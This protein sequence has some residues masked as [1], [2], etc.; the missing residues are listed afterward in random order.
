MKKL[1]IVVG[2]GA[3]IDFGLP[4]VS[5]VDQILDKAASQSHPLASDTNSNLYRYL[6]E[7]LQEYFAHSPIEHLRKEAT[8]E[9]VL[10]QINSLIPFTADPYW[11][12]GANALFA[13]HRI[14]EVLGQHW[15]PL[16]MNG[17]DL[18]QL[19]VAL[20]DALVFHFIDACENLHTTKA[21][22]LAKLRLFLTALEGEF[23]IGVVTL[24]YDN[25]IS[26]AFPSLH[27]GFDQT[28]GQFDPLLVLQRTDWHF[29]YH[30]H[31][32]IHFEMKHTQ[33]A[34]DQITW[35]NTP[36]K[37]YATS[38]S[39]RGLQDS[40]E[41]ASYPQSIFI[42]GYGK[43]HQILR[44]PFR[45]YFA[46]VNRLA[47][48][49]DSLLFLGYG[50]GDAHLNALF[51]EPFLRG[52][53]AVVIDW[54]ENDLDAFQTRQD[55]WSYQLR[56]TLPINLHEVASPTPSVP[57]LKAK[58]E[59]DVLRDQTSRLAI[60]YGGLMSACDHPQAIL[61]ALR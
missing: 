3:S 10:Y 14:P 51:L 5:R 27:T 49:A 50:F 41:G 15:R 33:T 42:A 1:L 4:S 18:K 39:G 17:E 22:E 20:Y 53:P 54:A 46:Q 9:D 57:A 31:G 55:R 37:S 56:N 34:M 48:E 7:R 47:Y 38:V 6:K 58:N 40:V 43:T 61:K 44:Q 52:V 35:A 25:I 30:L 32:S 11:Q 28:T 24:N 16:S 8:F 36:T 59:L 13:A 45:T 60:W 2:A 23:D 26:T 21:N 29:I 12:H 19:G